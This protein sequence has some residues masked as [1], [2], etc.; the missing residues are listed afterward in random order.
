MIEYT[1]GKPNAV[2]VYACRLRRPDMPDGLLDDE[3]LL[4]MEN[5]WYYCGSDQEC[6]YEVLGW[7]GPL[8]RRFP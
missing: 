3:F 2:G 5:R 7:I 4:W 1:T 8:R 6:R